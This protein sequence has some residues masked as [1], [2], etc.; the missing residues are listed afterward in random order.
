MHINQEQG[1]KDNFLRPHSVL[2]EKASVTIDSF[3]ADACEP[4]LHIQ[5]ERGGNDMTCGQPQV[6]DHI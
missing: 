2:S 3:C 6:V 5:E 4:A 1:D